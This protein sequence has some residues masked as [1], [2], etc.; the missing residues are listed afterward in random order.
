MCPKIHS[1][2]VVSENF[3]ES[4]IVSCDAMILRGGGMFSP[5]RIT[6]HI[7]S[8]IIVHIGSCTTPPPLWNSNKILQLEI[9]SKGAA[10][11]V[12]NNNE[13]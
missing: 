5:K 6:L 4:I 9:I 13:M 3:K 7:W 1:L 11:F 12:M 10:R 2:G 8:S